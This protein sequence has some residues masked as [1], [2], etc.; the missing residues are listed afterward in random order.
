MNCATRLSAGPTSR[1]SKSLR[2]RTLS[3]LLISSGSSSLAGEPSESSPNAAALPFES[4][5]SLSRI[6]NPFSLAL[7]SF[8][9]E[10]I[11]SKWNKTESA[12]IRDDQK[13][14]PNFEVGI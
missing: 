12:S 2:Q 8:E 9:K 6:P 13:R 10:I 1:A 11:I 7:Y 3:S 5:Q 14:P 4:S